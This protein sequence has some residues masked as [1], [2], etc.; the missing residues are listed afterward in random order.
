MNTLQE[1]T[2]K[3]YLQ[4]FNCSETILHAANEYYKLNLH[5]ED[6]K[7]MAGFGGGMFVGSTCGALIGSIAAISK[8]IIE[9]KA[10][11]EMD[12]I[13][14]ITQKCV[15]NFK[16]ELGAL[17]CAHIKPVHNTKEER[18]LPTCLLATKALEK[19]IREETSIQVGEIHEI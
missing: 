13:R 17:D 15:R 11:D 2:K 6:M 9:T 12:R 14:P 18:C 8:L 3:Y 1:I 10:H 4:G 7:V 16:E 5:E 19:T